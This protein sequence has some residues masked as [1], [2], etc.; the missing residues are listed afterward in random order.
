M[1]IHRFFLFLSVLIPKTTLITLP[2]SFIECIVISL[3]VC[4]VDVHWLPNDSLLFVTSN[5]IGFFDFLFIRTK[6]A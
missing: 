1:D 4:F 2:R 5:G 6:L 3:P